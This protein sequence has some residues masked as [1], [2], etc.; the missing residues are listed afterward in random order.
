MIRLGGVVVSAPGFA[1]LSP[2][3]PTRKLRLRAAVRR[4]S[5]SSRSRTF[6]KNAKVVRTRS[7]NKGVTAPKRLTLSDGVIT[8]D[9][10][11][12]AIDEHQIGH[13]AR[14]RRPA[15]ARPSST[16][17]TRTNTTSPPTNWRGCSAST[18]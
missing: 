1:L 15:V 5:R 9:A 17:S 16:S 12:Q 7:T 11:F 8:H 3:F 2:L 10:V 18:T 4:N 14:R 13:A 6:L